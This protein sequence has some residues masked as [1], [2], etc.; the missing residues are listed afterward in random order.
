MHQ[1]M[2]QVAKKKRIKTLNLLFN[3]ANSKKIKRKFKSFDLIIA[4]NVLNH[5]N[6]PEDFIKAAKNIMKKTLC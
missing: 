1:K 3:F 4:N 5:S 6:N 2:C